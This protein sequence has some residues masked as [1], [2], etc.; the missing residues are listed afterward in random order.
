MPGNS[1]T[2]PLLAALK[3]S[4]A[5]ALQKIFNSLSKELKRLEQSVGSPNLDDLGDV[6]I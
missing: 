4:D 3:G 2:A 1:W 5:I 6:V